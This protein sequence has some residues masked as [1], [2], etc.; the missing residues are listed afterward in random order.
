MGESGA[1]SKEVLPIADARLE[2]GAHGFAS[3]W[4]GEG[5]LLVARL[6]DNEVE[7]RGLA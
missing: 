3:T 6:D 1:R 2:A 5:H 4:T 7:I